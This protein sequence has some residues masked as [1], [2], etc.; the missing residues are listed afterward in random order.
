MGDYE[1]YYAKLGNFVE[2]CPSK[3]SQEEKAIV[4]FRVALE[5]STEA[6]GVHRS[7]HI[8]CKLLSITLGIVAGDESTDVDMMMETFSDETKH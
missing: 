5:A 2:N 1:E 6:G 3:L 7:T 8:M 4:L